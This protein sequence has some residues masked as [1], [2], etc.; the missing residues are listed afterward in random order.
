MAPQ[1]REAHTFLLTTR[2]T[3]SLQDVQAALQLHSR[4]E[5]AFVDEE[6]EE[7]S[8]RVPPSNTRPAVVILKVDRHAASEEVR[9]RTA[10]DRAS[11]E[12]VCGWLAAYPELEP[13]CYVLGSW[14]ALQPRSSPL[15]PLDVCNTLV[16]F[17]R[18]SSV[19]LHSEP[20]PVSAR[21]WA[22]NKAN[23]LALEEMRRTG[24]TAGPQPSELEREFD[25]ERAFCPGQVALD[26]LAR[27][28]ETATWQEPAGD[29]SED[30]VWAGPPG[31]GGVCSYGEARMR[32][33][34]RTLATV[35]VLCLANDAKLLIVRNLNWCGHRALAAL[36]SFKVVSQA[37]FNGIAWSPVMDGFA[38]AI[39]SLA[40]VLDGGSG[41]VSEC[42]CR[43]R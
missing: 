27:L 7:S 8:V 25:K 16:N 4:F 9:R 18:R 22:F 26:L 32:E 1:T 40:V 14:A 39:D 38:L 31:I 19:H 24:A 21:T 29:D 43:R 6:E 11:T 13:V 20:P 12:D 15:R 10:R 5:A 37:F 42:G 28:A 17:L 35:V 3:V 30:A 23:R 33:Y 2:E 41:L 34:A 36:S